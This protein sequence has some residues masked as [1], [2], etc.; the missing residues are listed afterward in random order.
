[1]PQ[2]KETFVAP[3]CGKEIVTHLARHRDIA[4]VQRGNVS[5]MLWGVIR[6]EVRAGW[7]A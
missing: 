3:D 4:M 6:K 5:A 1:M 7:N 2:K